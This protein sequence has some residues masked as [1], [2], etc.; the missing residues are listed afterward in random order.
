MLPGKDLQAQFFQSFSS[1]PQLGVLPA[2]NILRPP[3]QKTAHSLCQ[4][5]KTR[6]IHGSCLQPLRQVGRHILIDGIAAGAAPKQGFSPVPAQQQPRPLRPQQ[7]LVSRHGN[8]FGSQCFQRNR[9]ASGRLSRV[10]DKGNPPFPAAFCHLLHRQDIAEDIGYMGEDRPICPTVKGFLPF[11]QRVRP[12]KE[13]PAGHHHP[14]IQPVEG[15]GHR[16]VLKAGYHHPA[17]GPEQG[18]DGDIQSMGAVIC[19]HHLL[20]L[21][22]KQLSCRLPAGV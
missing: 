21:A 1:Q 6:H 3:A 11:P 7:A 15:T 18:M 17:A 13:L 14:G 2:E 22:G 8:E 20:R 12:V 5:G 16:V 9:Q 19:Q 10:H 4:S